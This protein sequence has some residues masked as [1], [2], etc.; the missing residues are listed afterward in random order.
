MVT[1]QVVA[2]STPNA[3]EAVMLVAAAEMWNSDSGWT[4][5]QQLFRESDSPTFPLGYA[6]F[7][8]LCFLAVE[9]AHRSELLGGPGACCYIAGR[10]DPVELVERTLY[11]P[12][13]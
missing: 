12:T 8:L 6:S 13:R 7:T 11:L 4:S 5:F 9:R 3:I 1:D 2:S 10:S